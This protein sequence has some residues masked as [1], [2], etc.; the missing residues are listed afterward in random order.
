MLLSKHTTSEALLLQDFEPAAFLRDYWQQKPLLMRNALPHCETLLSAEEL[1][2]LACENELESRLI[3]QQQDQWQLEHGPFAE[4]RF[5]DLPPSHWTLL[6]QAVDHW[7]AEIEQL[8]AYFRFIP[9]WRLDDVMVSYATEGGSVGPHLDQYDV[10]LIQLR[11]QREWQ[12]SAP[13][14]ELRENH[15]GPL[16]L[17]DNFIAEQRFVLSPGDILYLPPNLGHWGIARDNDCMTAS[18]GFRAPSQ[19]EI[20]SHFVD[21]L[22]PDLDSAQRYQDPAAS[23]GDSAHPGRIDDSVQRYLQQLLDNMLQQPEQLMRWFGS[24]LTSTSENL[25]LVP[26]D[27]E[28]NLNQLLPPKLRRSSD[29]RLAYYSQTEQ[30]L[31][32]VDGD[33]IALPHTSLPLVSALA[34][35]RH[36]QRDQLL[37][38][39]NCR[40]E[41]QLL[42][43]LWQH[44]VLIDD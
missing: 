25:Q 28:P 9:D 19:A 18:I 24:H 21:S 39:V 22:L 14:T 33:C 15:S 43:A 38:K 5:A 20:L 4:Q 16:R 7:V 13:D 42:A 37:E 27:D 3:I 1:A 12:L 11:G 44:E 32:F 6:V 23:L 35:H 10:F 34:D 2:G 26:V 17:V 30:L 41:R 31:F 8:K 29:S 40:Q 36:Y